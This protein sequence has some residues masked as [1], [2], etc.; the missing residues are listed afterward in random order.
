[1]E[2]R[3]AAHDAAQRETPASGTTVTPTGEG[4]VSEPRSPHEMRNAAT[5][6]ASSVVTDVAAYED[7]LGHR[8]LAV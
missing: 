3:R 2:R 8:L 6:Y 4:E 1:M 7:L 5:A